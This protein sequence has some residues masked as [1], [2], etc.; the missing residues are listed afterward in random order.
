MREAVLDF[1]A[2]S[3]RCSDRLLLHDVSFAVREGLLPDS[4]VQTARRRPRLCTFV[5]GVLSADGGAA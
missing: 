5:V 4:S 3:R 1:G 2:V